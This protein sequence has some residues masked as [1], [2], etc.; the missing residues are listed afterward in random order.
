MDPRHQAIDDVT[1]RHELEA[2][3]A[4]ELGVPEHRVIIDLPDPISFEAHF[5]IFEDD[6]RYEFSEKS[7]FSAD[8]VRTF[9]ETLRRIRLMIP[10]DLI[11]AETEG[12]QVAKELLERT[13]S[14]VE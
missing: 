4:R 2:Q 6:H 9:T 13:L 5:P 11:E 7:V 3:L 1:V 12:E 14:A 8:V 10:R